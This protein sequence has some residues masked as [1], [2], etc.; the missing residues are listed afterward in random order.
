[1]YKDKNIFK[2]LKI[3]NLRILQVKSIS[4]QVKTR[5]KIM[6]S[7]TLFKAVGVYDFIKI[8]YKTKYY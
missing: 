6:E 8:Y 7:E 2:L 4:K 5:E 3:I 1:M